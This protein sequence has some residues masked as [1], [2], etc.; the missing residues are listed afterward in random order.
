[1][2][3]WESVMRMRGRNLEDPIKE[4]AAMQLL[5]NYHDHIIS[6]I[7]VLQDSKYLYIIMPYCGS[8]L[9]EKVGSR[10]KL[11]LHCTRH[12]CKS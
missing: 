9:D 11:D 8:M 3:S 1:M 7:G 2:I 5:G 4:V 12:C 6:A 10:G